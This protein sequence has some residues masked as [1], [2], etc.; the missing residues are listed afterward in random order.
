MNLLFAH[1]NRF[2]KDKD[3]NI[4]SGG[5]F[6][7]SI[8]ENYLQNFNHI[9]FYGRGSSIHRKE[10]NNM[11]PP[12]NNISFI[13][14]DKYKSTKDFLINLVNIRNEL[15]PLV[16]NS[17]I[18]LA[19][20]PSFIGYIAVAEAYIQNKPVWIEQVG[21]GKESLS[22]HGS[23]MGK[24]IAH[25]ADIINKYLVKKA[26]FVSYVTASK[27]QKDYPASLKAITI[28]LSDVYIEEIFS[29][30]DIKI[31]RF[32]RRPF[33]ICL[34]GA[35]DVNYKGQKILLKAISLLPNHIKDNIEINFIG[36]GDPA[37]IISLANDLNLKNSL[38]HIGP[39]Q[40]GKEINHF[41]SLMSLY[42]QCSLTEGLPRSMIEAMAVG[43]PVIGS[44]V[45][46]IPE[47]VNPSFIHHAG[48]FKKLSKDIEYLYINRK[49]LYNESLRSI[50]IAAD[51]HISN[52][53]EK[54]KSFYSTINQIV[55]DKKSKEK[56]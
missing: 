56:I 51:F 17:D 45:G 2:Y 5:A 24:L 22:K 48:D 6:P 47:L 15:K 11:V 19:R 30:V 52:L 25:P 7:P 31:E 21:N 29:A 14:T 12:S 37:S 42:I 53:M 18:V 13:L 16:S 55:L 46:G 8:W 35:L 43:C 3:G 4:F 34:I 32:E 44:N 38:G 20:L 49:E 36:G 10:L 23:L 28:A 1:C 39:L 33:R 26:D 50:S 27:L 41:L 54:R 9:T 40:A